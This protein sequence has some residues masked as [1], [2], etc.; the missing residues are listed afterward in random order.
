MTAKYLG[1]GAVLKSNI[2]TY[3]DT[4]LSIQRRLCPR[5]QTP[6]L[7]GL[8]CWVVIVEWKCLG[9]VL[10][11]RTSQWPVDDSCISILTCVCVGLIQLFYC[12]WVLLT[13][14][15]VLCLSYLSLQAL[16]TITSVAEV[17]D[18]NSCDWEI[19]G[20]FGIVCSASM[21]QWWFW[22]FLLQFEP[23]CCKSLSSCRWV[24]GKWSL[25]VELQYCTV[26]LVSFL[27]WC[28][29]WVQCIYPLICGQSLIPLNDQ[30]AISGNWW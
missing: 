24:R 28:A 9:C 13:S 3:V 27:S 14:K 11:C 2:R 6:V 8:Y 29:E 4:H 18:S 21:Q 17:A 19:T 16:H 22:I 10:S 7:R 30:F 1:A 26:G 5:V 15:M 20:C 12:V 23:A 25:R